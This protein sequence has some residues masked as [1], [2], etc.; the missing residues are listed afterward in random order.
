MF[1]SIN[2]PNKYDLLLSRSGIL[3]ALITMLMIA[4]ACPEAKWSDI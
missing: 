1:L 3:T 2:P 4:D